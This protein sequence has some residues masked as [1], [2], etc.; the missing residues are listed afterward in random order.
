M[1]VARWCLKTALPLVASLGCASAPQ[2]PPSSAGPSVA[3]ASAGASD[4]EPKPQSG[5]ERGLAL[6]E[7]NSDESPAPL[8]LTPALA[9]ARSSYARRIAVTIG[10][11]DY[12]GDVPPLRAAVS[13][14]ER[15][16]ALFRATG[17]DQVLT[18]T[19]SQATR[20]GILD[21]LE[22][23]IPLETGPR[24]QV[25]VFF[26]GHGQTS[27]SGT[28]YIVPQDGTLGVVETGISVQRLKESA[29]VMKARHVLYLMDACFSGSMLTESAPSGEK[30]ALSY[31]NAQTSERL[32]QV[33]TAGNKNEKVTETGG[34]GVF[35]KAVHDGLA[36]G[37]ADQN[38]DGVVTSFEIFA[39]AQ[40]EVAGAVGDR[41]HPQMGTLEGQG[42]NVFWD[43]RRVPASERAK[44]PEREM[45]PGKENVL[46]KIHQLIEK[47]DWTRA[48]KTLRDLMLK[49]SHP[50]LNLLL[51]E[52]Y[53]GADVLG[54]RALIGAELAAVEDADIPL[55]EGQQRRMLTLRARTERAQRGEF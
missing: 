32:I 48:E 9:A 15:I 3:L 20:A 51:A 55:T 34:W 44:E 39:F 37:A 22:R 41:Q 16:A 31:W 47:Q 40:S 38:R 30:S 28:G 35:T 27:A 25:V 50:E 21:V 12:R 53:V 5:T 52:V 1:I 13:D 18:L 54:N 29:L 23:K 6:S 36:T 17:F 7:E 10:I 2:R 14:A 26:A 45:I 11:N 8:E 4:E 33:V 46:L 49:G 19:D 43:E 42:A 24:D